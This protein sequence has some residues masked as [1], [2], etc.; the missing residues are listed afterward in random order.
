MPRHRYE[1]RLRG[2][3]TPTMA[4]EFEQ[5][6]LQHQRPRPSTRCS[7]ARSTTAPRSTVCSAASRRWAWSSSKSAGRPTT[8]RPGPPLQHLEL[9][10]PDDRVGGAR[11]RAS[12]TPLS[13]ASSRCSRRSAS[14]ARSPRSTSS[15][16]GTRAR[17][18][19]SVSGS[20]NVGSSSWFLGRR[21]GDRCSGSPPPAASR[22]GRSRPGTAPCKR[23]GT[24]LRIRRSR[25]LER[26]A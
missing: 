14:V 18:F 23:E 26:L 5:L 10:G 21:R 2:R 24:A 7:K 19:R 4:S 1:I 11:P 17:R 9:T 6:E 25:E 16:V 22:T 15:T 12:G 3:L 13:G 8:R 20:R